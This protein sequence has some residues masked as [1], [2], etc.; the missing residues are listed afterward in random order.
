MEAQD[1]AQEKLEA[2]RE[3][4]ATTRRNIQIIDERIG[5]LQ[6]GRPAL[7][8]AADVSSEHRT[9]FLS[10]VSDVDK[11][12]G[13]RIGEEGDPASYGFHNPKTG[14]VRIQEDAAFVC[15]DI[16]VAL[17]PKPTQIVE[18]ADSGA[19]ASN[20]LNPWLRLTDVNTGRNLVSGFTTGP[21]DLDRG[22]IPA[23]YLTSARRGLGL[24]AK[25]KLF[26]EFTIPRAGSVRVTVFNMGG[27]FVIGSQFTMR[28]FVTLMGYKVLGA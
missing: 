5:T 23:T 24:N 2:A 16:L 15:T 25:N 12:N 22:A 11:S 13:I 6:Q 8:L 14:I 27:D 26:S 21:M 19:L 17:S 20:V 28:V 10:A 1:Q 7:A 3:L 4:L 18:A 9:A